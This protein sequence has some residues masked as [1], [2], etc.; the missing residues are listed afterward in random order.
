MPGSKLEE[1]IFCMF[2][3]GTQTNIHTKKNQIELNKVKLTSSTLKFFYF[4]TVFLTRK[5]DVQISKLKS[6]SDSAASFP[7]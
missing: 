5:S 1:K 7:F 3:S 6:F 4:K 2:R